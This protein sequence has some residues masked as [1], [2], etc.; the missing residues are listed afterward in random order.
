M[1]HIFGLPAVGKSTLA[2]HLGHKVV[3]HGV[4]VRYINMDD[5][6]ISKSSDIFEPVHSV[7]NDRTTSKKLVSKTFRDITLSWYSPEFVSATAQ[8][9]IEWAKGLSNTTLLILD[10]CDL[11][12]NMIT[13]KDNSFLRVLDALSKASPY[14]HTI[15]TSRLQLNLLDAK[16][17]KLQPLDSEFAIE[18]LQLFT[19]IITFNDSRMINELVDGIPL[20]LKIVGSLVSTTRQ[21]NLIITELQQNLIQTLTPEDIRPETQENSPCSKTLI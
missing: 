18:L 5:S 19:P 20:A 2:I 3:S 12:L 17:Y 6:H 10:N 8:A 16:P 13:K 9:L 1:V 14:L 21:P 15:T 7:D 11:L 4:A